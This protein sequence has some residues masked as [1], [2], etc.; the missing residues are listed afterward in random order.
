[1]FPLLQKLPLLLVYP[2]TRRKGKEKMVKSDI[3]KKK[4]LQEQIDVQDTMEL[5]EEMVRDAQRMNEQI[6][7][8]AE[9]ARIHAEKELQ[10][11]I[12]G[13][14]M[15]NEIIAKYLQEYHQFATELPIGRRIELI[16]DLVKYQD[17]YAKDFIPI[18][19]KEESER[20]KR[21]RIRFEQDSAKR[22]KTSEEV[23]EE[24]L[25]EM[26]EQIPVE[27]VRITFNPHL[28][29]TFN[30]QQEMDQQYPTVAKIPVLDTKKFKQWQFRIQQ[31]LQHENYALWEVIE[32]G[33]SYV[34]P[35]SSSS[36]TITD[37]ASDESG[38]KSGRTVTLTAE[39]IKYKTARELW[40]AILKT[41]GGNEATKKTKKNL[42]KQQYGNFKAEGLETLEQTFNRLQVIVGMVVVVTGRNNGDEVAVGD[43]CVPITLIFKAVDPFSGNNINYNNKTLYYDSQSV[44]AIS[45]NPVQHSRTKNIHTRSHFIKEHV[46]NG[47][48]ELYFVRTEYQLAG[49]FT[50]ALPKNRFKYLVKRIGMRY[51]T[52]TELEVLA[53][54]SA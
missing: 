11:M 52:P 54:E 46:K 28:T 39:D 53:K 51:L 29:F 16:S 25:K 47:I 20:L 23:L 42:L 43:V 5:E 32:F 2:Y 41:F 8:D 17:N 19:S 7:R 50:K 13:L 35:A 48:I 10:I 9:I 44:I 6:A 14:D 49:L 1:W 26:M 22:Q 36:T 21:K 31:Y 18:G 12:D 4:K 45:C 27:E 34:V 3:P 38:S 15:N 37:T 40:A 30:S 33:D 24:K